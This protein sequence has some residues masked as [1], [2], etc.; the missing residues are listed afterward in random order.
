[1]RRDA[2]LVAAAL[3]VQVVLVAAIP[4]HETI[5]RATGRTVVVA[6][7]PVDPYD[8]MRG[9]HVSFT[10]RHL[11]SDLPG[12]DPKASDGSIAWAVLKAPRPGEAAVAV[13]IVRS[14]AA[15]HGDAVLRVRYRVADESGCSGALRAA[16]CRRLAAAP[17]A[18]YA[19]EA[20][21][22]ALGET[23]RGYDA[24]AELRVTADGDA[25]LLRLTPSGGAKG[26]KR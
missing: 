17:N 26:L 13:A 23:L 4:L 10:Y 16:G 9:Y 5:T 8:P 1:M 6:V 18:W 24:V 19:D 20:S 22:S 15:G 12:F 25:S 11:G 2:L 21:V 14:P 7:D 3:A